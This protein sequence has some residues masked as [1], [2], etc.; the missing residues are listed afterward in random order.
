MGAY[1]LGWDLEIVLLWQWDFRCMR[2]AGALYP[3]LESN[4]G[5]DSAT[6]SGGHPSAIKRRGLAKP[7][8][9]RPDASFEAKAAGVSFFSDGGEQAIFGTAGGS[10]ALL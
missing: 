3:P 2:G 5:V 8:R 6:S 1:E 10:S 4:Q 7:F 9:S